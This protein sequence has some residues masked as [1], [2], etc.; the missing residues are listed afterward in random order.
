MLKLKK[1][2][3]RQ[4]FGME[5]SKGIEKVAGC[6]QKILSSANASKIWNNKYPSLASEAIIQI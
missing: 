6:E 2:L 4:Y 3:L 1:S 5:S